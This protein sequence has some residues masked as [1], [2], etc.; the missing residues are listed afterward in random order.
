[1]ADTDAVTAYLDEIRG[2]GYHNGETGAMAH[3]LSDAAAEDV[4][5]LL[6]AI[7]GVL[8]EHRPE[9]SGQRI[10]SEAEW[11]ESCGYCWPCST[12]RAISRALL[13]EGG[14]DG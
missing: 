7:E 14:T 2:R 5:R 1:M 6:A 3:R 4:P 11:C 8:A 12:V 10:G 13:G 9:D